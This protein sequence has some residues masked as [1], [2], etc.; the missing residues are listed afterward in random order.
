EVVA[1]LAKEGI[2]AQSKGDENIKIIPV[3]HEKMFGQ[4]KMSENSQF[5]VF[6][7]LTHPGDSLSSTSTKEILALPISAPWGS[8]TWAVE[9]ALKLKPKIIIPIHDYLLK[10]QINQMFSERLAQY[11]KE[12]GIDFKLMQKGEKIEI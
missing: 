12:K 11:F 8:T 3:K 2:K 5:D 9:V 7:R 10:D 4:D 1:D 6:G